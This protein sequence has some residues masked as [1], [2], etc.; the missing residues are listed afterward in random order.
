[1]ISEMIRVIV[2][3]VST[4]AQLC[5]VFTILAGITKALSSTLKSF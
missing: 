4:F 2:M 5:A 1:M 3:S